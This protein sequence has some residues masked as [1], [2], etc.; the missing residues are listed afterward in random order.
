[1]TSNSK[2]LLNAGQV[3]LWPKMWLLQSGS[4]DLSGIKFLMVFFGC[5][6]N[7][8]KKKSNPGPQHQLD[9]INK[10]VLL[11]AV[12]W[13]AETEDTGTILFW[14]YWH[15]GKQKGWKLRHIIINKWDLK[16]HWNG[17]LLFHSLHIHHIQK[18]QEK[19]SSEFSQSTLVQWERKPEKSALSR[20]HTQVT[21]L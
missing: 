3:N 18:Q 7:R 4:K 6:R 5:G 12:C 9:L 14:L 13:Q 10:Q 19:A 8:V 1:M 15:L 20:Q 16:I 2:V 21:V 11:M 17:K